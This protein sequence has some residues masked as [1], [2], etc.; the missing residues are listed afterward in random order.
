MTKWVFTLPQNP[1]EAFAQELKLFGVFPVMLVVSCRDDG[2]CVFGWPKYLPLHMHSYYGPEATKENV[3]RYGDK[4]PESS[5]R[6]LYPTMK[7][8]YAY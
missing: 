1:D 5:A 2:W 8:P 4:L 3:L 7:G 6:H